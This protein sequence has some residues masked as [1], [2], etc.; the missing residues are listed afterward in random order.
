MKTIK[1]KYLLTL[2]VLVL[3][4]SLP[5]SGCSRSASRIEELENRVSKLQEELSEKEKTIQKIQQERNKLEK[6][7]EGKT[8]KVEQEPPNE[9]T[10]DIVGNEEAV[11]IDVITKYVK[12]IEEDNF[13]E[14]K[15][16]VA[17]YALDLVNLKEFEYENITGRESKTVDVESY[18]VD[19]IAGDKA[20][21]YMSFTEHLKGYDDTKYDLIT[22]GKVYLEKVN[23]KWK[24]IDYTRKNH[25]IS[26]VLYVFEDFCKA[27][28]NITISVNR[29]LFSLQDKY[30]S[31]GY[32]ISNEN[33]FEIG[34]NVYHSTIVGPDKIQNEFNGYYI[35]CDIKTIYPN[36]IG[37]ADIEYKWS[38]DAVGNFIIY[39]G[40]IW[41]GDNYNDIINDIV[42]E[43][44]LS[45]AVRY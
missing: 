25:L 42:S 35:G 15:K 28:K 29:V 5:I 27:H 21:G 34:T 19:K 31:V 36:A 1:V 41:R 33:N 9:Q 18:K 22:E 17:K 12:A 30:V 24:I 14:Q 3:A 23:N 32:I 39:F 16:Y 37:I 38:N 40:D 26:E 4:L 44:D 43:V 13:N 45:K 10:K 6:E 7:L 20:E 11:I 8:E 2:I